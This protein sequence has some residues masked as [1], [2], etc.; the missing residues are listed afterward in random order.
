MHINLSLLILTNL[1]DFGTYTHESG[2]GKGPA[3][4][5]SGRTDVRTDS[6]SPGPGAY[7]PEALNRSGGVSMSG[8]Y[9]TPVSAN[10]PGPGAYPTKRQKPFILLT[11]IFVIVFL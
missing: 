11:C 2:I 3:F 8:R 10:G 6:A 5:L 9:A 7:T 4:S 1:S